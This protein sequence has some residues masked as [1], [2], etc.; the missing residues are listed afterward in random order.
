MSAKFPAVLLLALPGFV[1]VAQETEPVAPSSPSA[2]EQAEAVAQRKEELPDWGATPQTFQILLGE[3]LLREGDTLRAAAIYA[4]LARNSRDLAVTR[5]ALE[6][7]GAVGDSSLALELARQWRELEPGSQEANLALLSFLAANGEV[8]EMAAPFARLLAAMPER[9]ADNFLALNRSL[10]RHAVPQAV[11]GLVQQLA[12]PYPKLP[13]AHYAVAQAAAIAEDFKTALASVQRARSLRPDWTA[14]LLLETQILLH[15]TQTGTEAARDKATTTA[16]TLL[17]QWLKR[18]PNVTEVRMALA[19]I[20]LFGQRYP[21]ARAQFDLLLKKSPDAPDIIYSV[22]MLALQEKDYGM[23]RRLLTRLTKL[24]FADQNNVRY[25]LGML[26]M[27]SGHPDAARPHFEAVDGGPQYLLARSRLAQNLAQA[28]K[29]EEAVAFL[30]NSHAQT[31]PDKIRLTLLEAQLLNDAARHAEAYATLEAALQETP[32]VSELL[33]DAALTAERSGKPEVMETHLKKLIELEP[34]NAHAYNA[35]GYSLA[36]RNL[37]LPEAHAL[38]A[39]AVQLAPGDPFIMDSLGWVLYRQ[40]KLEEAQKTLQQAYQIKPDPE[41]A[42][43]L[44]EVRWVQGDREAA[45]RIWQKAAAETPGNA[46]LQTA[47]RKFTAQG[48]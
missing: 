7:A 41:I 20:Y 46:T 44:G 47:I 10:S 8:E 4:D 48:Q 19:R 39:R 25:F 15:P 32:E 29:V 12:Q 2:I 17:K 21:E 9:L 1:A 28:G 30:R 22:A 14:A 23:A 42:A 18:H 45:R 40:G 36:D 13:E 33:Y 27:E 31:A 38:I 3:M 35:L 37:R 11:L 24:P 43:H 16:A 34:E 26:E 5:R 6:I